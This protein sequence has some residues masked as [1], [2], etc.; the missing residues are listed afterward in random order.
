MAVT[1]SSQIILKVQAQLQ[2]VDAIGTVADQIAVD[3]SHNYGSGTGAGQAN[4][5][6]RSPARS[7]NASSSENLDLNAVLLD[8]LGQ[9]V[10]L[11]RVVAIIISAAAA[12]TN[13]VLVG[14]AASNAFI[15]WVNDSTDIVVVRPGGFFAIGCGSGDSTAY[16][17]TAATGDI[18]KVA[19]SSSGTAVVYD[20]TIIGS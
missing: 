15:N 11:T 5:I 17:V 10:T 8:K 1:Q 13:N 3:Y 19:N 2:N 6:W 18:L 4:E 9:T 12:N 7:I 14:G 20:I 16:V